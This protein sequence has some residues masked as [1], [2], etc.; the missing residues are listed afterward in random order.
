MKVKHVMYAALG[1]LAL[2]GA[3]YTSTD[4]KSEEPQD[5]K[6]TKMEYTEV[7][8]KHI[9]VESEQEAKDI[10]Q[11]IESKEISFDDAA[12]QYSKCPSGRTGGDLGF[13]GKGMMVKEFE[14]SAFSQEPG[15][16]SEPVKTQFGWHL[17]EVIERR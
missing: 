10:A 15:K 2:A 7:H 8:A 9:L 13:F 1:A 4:N 12:K 3:V 5:I 11:K 14:D 16:V 17:I 6:E